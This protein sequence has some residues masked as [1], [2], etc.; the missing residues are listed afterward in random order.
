MG[1]TTSSTKCRD[2]VCA[3]LNSVYDTVGRL[4]KLVYPDATGTI[5]ANSETV[6]YGY[7][8]S[9]RFSS[10]VG[11]TPYVNKISYEPD[12]QMLSVT[13]GNGTSEQFGDDPNRR[14]LIAAKVLGSDVSHSVLYSASY[15]HDAGGCSS[16]I[17]SG[18][19]WVW[20]LKF[21]YDDLNRLPQVTGGQNQQFSYDNIGNMT[22]NSA[23]GSYTYPPPGACSAPN[24]CNT[25]PHAV[26]TAG[27]NSYAYDPNGNMISSTGR[28][29]AWNYD[30]FPA[31]VTTNAGTTSF[32][33][34]A[35]NQRISKRE[36]SDPTPTYYFNP[37]VERTPGGGFIY[38][39]YAGR[40]LVARRQSVTVSWY[41]QDHLGSVRLITDV[42]GNVVHRYDYSAFGTT[43]APSGY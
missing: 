22:L 27:N 29:I 40:T 43:L 32:D 26:Q 25:R 20:R 8:G 39:Y 11:S 30:N 24:P 36:P 15:S 41:N 31:S 17:S 12:S 16:S 3:S 4:S 1:R 2:S 9:G 33:Y 34:D 13:Y 14:W 21:T 19:N 18:T 38:S 7:D 35:S 28:T 5:S 37:W 10:V 42:K 6:L 23:V